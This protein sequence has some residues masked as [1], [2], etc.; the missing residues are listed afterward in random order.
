MISDFLDKRSRLVLQAVV[1]SYIN[2]PEPVGSRYVTK[3]YDLGFSPATIRNIMADLEEF[4]FLSQPH[5]SAGRVPT[6]KGY[7]FFVDALPVS[8]E[9][10]GHEDISNEF[11]NHFTGKLQ[12]IKDDMSVL[13]SEVTSTLSTLSHYVSVALPPKPENTTF[14]RMELIKYKRNI[15]IAILLTDEGVF[16]NRM[17]NVPEEVTQ[18]D[19][20]R[21]AD[22]IN[23]EYAGYALD[24]I[25]RTL[26]TRMK[27][28]KVLWDKLVSKA[29][30]ICEQ[31][32]HIA[33]DDVFISG[34][35]DVMDLPDFSD[36]ARIKEL[37]KAIKDKHMML[38]LLEEFSESEGVKVVI[39][40][41]NSIED[42]K[43]LSVV[44][45]TYKDGER[46][47]GVIALIGPKRMNYARAISMVDVVARCVS[48][49]FGS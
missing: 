10:A 13:F 4:G 48:K 49:T 19:L 12:V 47:I 11:I 5:T 22:Y 15:V 6:D 17:L 16:R 41:E 35:Y 29:I 28:E 30:D 18:E 43:G 45:T 24:E 46:P 39:G 44:T 33:E 21:I 14:N 23:V 37:S 31:A 8:E 36:M 25:R 1:Q 32:L 42:L 3:K 20:N 26:V 2:S 9:A 7:R 40:E 34:L 38:K 27:Y